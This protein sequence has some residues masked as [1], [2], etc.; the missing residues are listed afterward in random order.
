MKLTVEQIAI[1]NH[2]ATRGANQQ[3]FGDVEG[4][5]DLV[6]KGLMKFV[7]KSSWCQDKIFT[8]TEEG[9][10]ELLKIKSVAS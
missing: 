7:G 3:Y 8:I 9:K 4:M 2:T 1:L 5:S 10:E 6:E